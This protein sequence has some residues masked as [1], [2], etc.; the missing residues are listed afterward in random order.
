[1]NNVNLRTILND[2]ERKRIY[3][4]NAL[5]NRKNEL[6]NQIP[7]LKQ[8]DSELSSSSISVAKNLLKSNKPELLTELQK[9]IQSLKEEKKSILNSIGKDESYLNIHYDCNLCKDTGYIIEGFKTIKCNCLKQKIFDLEYNKSNISNLSEQNFSNFKST[10]YSDVVDKEKYKS[11]ISPREN[12]EIIKKI[13][14]NFIKNF[15]SKE[16]KNLLFTGNTGL[17]KTFLSSCIANELLKKGKTVLYQ[18]APVMFDTIIDYRFGKNTSNIYNN[19]L[20]VDLLI[21]DDLGTESMNNMKFSELFNIINTRL[22]NQKNHCTK[23]IIST[24]LSLQN[25][26]HS[27]EERVVSRFVGNYNICRF[28]GNDIRFI[29][30]N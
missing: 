6:Y 19:L 29:K 2:Y 7:R 1:M 30:N 4:M 21:I 5:E 8:I 23:T 18:T 9:N 3:E 15:D 13:C 26:L 24:N 22:L 20:D 14:L 11:D 12:I 16:E 10:V 27:Y 17:G 28:F 25:L